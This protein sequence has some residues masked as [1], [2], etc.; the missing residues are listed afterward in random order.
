MSP[1]GYRGMAEEMLNMIKSTWNSR[2]IPGEDVEIVLSDCWGLDF[3][4]EMRKELEMMMK[5]GLKF[6]TKRLTL[7]A[8][9]DDVGTSG[10]ELD[11]V[12]EIDKVRCPLAS[13]RALCLA[14]LFIVCIL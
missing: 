13:A 8:D 14:I 7:I 9:F 11:I 6:S 5:E 10:C 1:D 4:P 12:T 3:N 2:A